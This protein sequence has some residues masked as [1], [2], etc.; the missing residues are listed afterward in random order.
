MHDHLVTKPNSYNPLSVMPAV[1][2][3]APAAMGR[4]GHPVMVLE[5]LDSRVYA[6]G[7]LVLD[8]AARMTGRRMKGR[9]FFQNPS[10]ALIVTERSGLEF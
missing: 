1:V 2:E 6:F 5:T 10:F 7:E 9:R 3:P 8:F 4:G